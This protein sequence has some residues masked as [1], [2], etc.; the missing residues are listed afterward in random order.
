MRV[1][2]C[3]AEMFGIFDVEKRCSHLHESTYYEKQVLSC[4]R[5]HHFITWPDC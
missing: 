2:P 4:R 5:E 3:G 1:A